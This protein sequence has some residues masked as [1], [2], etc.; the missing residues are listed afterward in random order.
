MK[1]LIDLYKELTEVQ[2][3]MLQ[4]LWWAYT[5][6]TSKINGNM[7]IDDVYEF[8]ASTSTVCAKLK[9][10]QKRVDKLK[11]LIDLEEDNIIYKEAKER[12]TK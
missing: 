7:V 1:R 10:Y 4:E 2:K 11:Q 3:K 12:A 8:N 5:D 9:E 6:A